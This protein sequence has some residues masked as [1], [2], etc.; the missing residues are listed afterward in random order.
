M[1]LDF[2]RKDRKM[3]KIFEVVKIV[4]KELFWV[5]V[6]ILLCFVSLGLSGFLII[7]VLP[8]IIRILGTILI[9]LG[10]I[11]LIFVL[12]I[13]I[14]FVIHKAST[15]YSFAK[16]NNTSVDEAWETI[17]PIEVFLDT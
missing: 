8:E 11:M 9:A 3:K 16:K 5:F 2:E 15:V 10:V 4:V 7:K 12:V 14:A 6:I 1:A 13:R 17:D